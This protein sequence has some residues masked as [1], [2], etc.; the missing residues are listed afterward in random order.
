MDDG[1]LPRIVVERLR[2]GT[3]GFELYT[4]RVAHESASSDGS[5]T[6]LIVELQDGH[7]IEA[8]VMRHAKGR[9]TLCVSSQVGCKMGCTFCATGTLGELGNLASFEILEQLAHANRVAAPLNNYDSVI[10]AIGVMTDDKAFALSASKITVSTV[11]VIPRMRTLTRDAPGTCLALSLHAPTQELRQKIVPTATAYKLDDLMRVL[12]EYL[13]SGPKMKTMIEYC[14]LGGVNDDETCAEKLGEL[15]RGKE[16][17]I[18]LNLIPLNPTDTPA[19]HMPPTPEAVRKMMEILMK[20][21]GLFVTRRH[22][23]GD[24]IAGACGQLA[25]K[26]PGDPDMEDMMAPRR[27]TSAAKVRRAPPREERTSPTLV[28]AS[29]PSSSSRAQR[30]EYALIG[31][32]VLSAGMLAYALY[33]RRR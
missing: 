23:M 15:F 33:S 11:G 3:S 17:K 27:T 16:E 19:G 8:C 28:E 4:T 29:Q 6:K 10:E 26:T 21:Y 24:D 7:K 9:T 18:I 22:T 32:S 12:E 5:T 13:A 20:K 30:T 1:T 31:V 25:L 14:V 2:D